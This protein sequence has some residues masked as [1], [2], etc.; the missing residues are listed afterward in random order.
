R[1]LDVQLPIERE[2]S[3]PGL[4]P[5]T[6]EILADGSLQLNTQPVPRERLGARL[7][8]IYAN[9]PDKVLFVK[10]LE[11]VTYGDVVHVL[12]VARGAGV[13]VLG[14]VLPPPAEP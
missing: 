10:A 12:D 3:E 14:A 8:E 5:I 6:L 9:R 4:P 1:S 7:E 11:G 13:E 2:S